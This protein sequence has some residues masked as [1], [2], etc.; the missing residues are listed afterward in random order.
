MYKLCT[1]FVLLLICSFSFAQVTGKLTDTASHTPVNNAV[2]ALLQPSDSLLLGF[3]R[4]NSDGIFS[5]KSPRPGDY[6]LITMHPEY[7]DFADKITI[8][9]NSTIYPSI[10]LTSKTKLMEGI[11]VN[12]ARSIRVKGDTTIFT[13]DSF[14]VSANANVEELL[15]KLPGLREL[16]PTEYFP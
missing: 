6:L 1:V 13:A 7:A 3:T 12:S 14:K 4:T 8:H 16:I 5:L 11:V 9:S 15:K 2:V 10:A